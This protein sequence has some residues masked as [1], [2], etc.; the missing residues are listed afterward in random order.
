MVKTLRVS[1]DLDNSE[2][3][4]LMDRQVHET[5]SALMGLQAM[6][7]ANMPQ[8]VAGSLEAATALNAP[9][10]G[11]LCSRFNKERQSSSL[12]EKSKSIT[13]MFFGE[14]GTVFNGTEKYPKGLA[15]PDDSILSITRESLLDW[16]ANAFSDLSE[17][18]K[19]TYTTRLT[20]FFLWIENTQGIKGFE[21]PAKGL[22]PNKGKAASVSAPKTS[23]RWSDEEAELI[24]SKTTD[25]DVGSWLIRIMAYTGLRIDEAA[26]LHKSDLSLCV[27]PDSGNP[28]Y[29]V[30]VDITEET[31]ESKKLKNEASK[32]VVV[33]GWPR[34]TVEAFTA[35]LE[36][37]E[38]DRVF[39]KLR[40]D[41]VN[42]YSVSA[43]AETK[44][45]YM[46]LE[47]QISAKTRPNH[48]WR[49]M[50]N[51]RCLKARMPLRMEKRAMGHSLSGDM[52]TG[53]YAEDFEHL[54]LYQTLKECEVWR[55]LL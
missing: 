34:N 48:A 33:L 12:S 14:G 20:T 31:A 39:S 42:G 54:E 43:G 36:Q 49:H 2:T 9:T 45:V 50:F 44:K 22:N 10:F 5:V 28:Y 21:N 46:L 55:N 41:K 29:V 1:F 47:G 19:K 35:W 38:G 26:Q 51:D 15:Q 8:A 52:T 40:R 6:T 27:C 24:L 25:N 11:E 32:R 17:S 3:L 53:T 13:A 23:K 16:M 37:Q 30:N 4:R 7:A 18:S